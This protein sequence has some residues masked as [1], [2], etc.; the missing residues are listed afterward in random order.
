MTTQTRRGV[1]KQ[2]AAALLATGSSAGAVATKKAAGR[3]KACL[4]W[5][6][7]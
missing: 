2:T 4:H 5:T 6:T 3:Q 7:Q 1:L